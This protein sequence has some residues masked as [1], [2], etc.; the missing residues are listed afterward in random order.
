M[1]IGRK[2]GYEYVS[3]CSSCQHIKFVAFDPG[4]EIVALRDTKRSP[5]HCQNSVEKQG[6]VG[7]TLMAKLN[8]RK[9]LFRLTLGRFLSLPEWLSISGAVGSY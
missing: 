5:P 2:E 9:I 4:S 1:V 6:N 8:A 3:E 7:P